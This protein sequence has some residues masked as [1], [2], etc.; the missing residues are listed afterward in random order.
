MR[1]PRKTFERLRELLRP[2][3][4]DPAEELYRLKWVERDVILPIK[5]LYLGVLIYYFYFT[6]WTSDQMTAMQ[7]AQSLTAK[8]FSLYLVINITLGIYLM[9]VQRLSLVWGQRLVSAMSVLD[10]L[11]LGALTVITGGFNSV[12]Y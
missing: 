12:L 11:F 8:A 4:P 10:S 6:S 5:A 9:K 3:P 2:L 7:I 1:F